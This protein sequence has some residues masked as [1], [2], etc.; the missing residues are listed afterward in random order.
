M[1]ISSAAL[2]QLIREPLTALYKRWAPEFLSRVRKPKDRWIGLVEVRDLARN[3][4]WDFTKE[5]LLLLDLK[6]ALSE[7]GRLGTLTFIGRPY[8]GLSDRYSYAQARIEI[9]KESWANMQ[10][11][12]DGFIDLDCH[13]NAQT[14]VHL[15]NPIGKDAYTDIYIDRRAGKLWLRTEAALVKGQTA[16]NEAAYEEARKRR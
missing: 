1:E 5:P 2:V 11:S 13:D 4:G 8:E 7:A 10:V 6:N 12:P 14:R 9:P 16:A 15:R 3:S